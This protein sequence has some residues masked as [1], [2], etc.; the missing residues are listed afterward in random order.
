MK[1]TTIIAIIAVVVIAIFLVSCGKSDEKFVGKWVETNNPNSSF[2][3]SKSDKGLVIQTGEST[4]IPAEA[5]GTTLTVDGS[6]FNLDE[7]KQELSVDGLFD[8]KIVFKKI[9]SEAK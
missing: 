3:I 9:A 2:V 5:K 8:S 6:T 4:T 7:Q 1:K